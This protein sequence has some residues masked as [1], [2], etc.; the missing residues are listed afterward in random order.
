MDSVSSR[1]AVVT[2]I[3][4]ELSSP[5]RSSPSEERIVSSPFPRTLHLKNGPGFPFHTLRISDPGTVPDARR[6]ATHLTTHI[7]HL[8]YFQELFR[9]GGAYAR[10]SHYGTSE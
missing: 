8:A 6:L 7:C 9:A 2:P 10:W 3:L 5:L 4:G 1:R